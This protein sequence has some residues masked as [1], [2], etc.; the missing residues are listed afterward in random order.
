MLFKVAELAP[1]QKNKHVELA[2]GSL[3]SWSV[4]EH[5]GVRV[6]LHYQAS[7]VVERTWSVLDGNGNMEWQIE[8][9][10]PTRPGLP[11]VRNGWPRKKAPGGKWTTRGKKGWETTPSRRISNPSV[12][13]KLPGIA[14]ASP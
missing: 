1:L 12:G 9:R 14:R 8:W 11:S 2:S 10:S 5:P 13:P 7:T 4:L 6:W 3:P